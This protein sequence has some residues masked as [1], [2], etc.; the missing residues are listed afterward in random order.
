MKIPIHLGVLSAVIVGA[1]VRVDAQTTAPP[2]APPLPVVG[3]G[4][5][6]PEYQGL[7]CLIGAIIAAVG[8]YGYSDI[9]A[10]AA[11]GAVTNP[12]LLVPV[13]AT[14]FAVGCAVGSTA[15]PAFLPLIRAFRS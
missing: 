10:V 5:T 3:L 6:Q 11:T 12:V 13:M 7:G 8:T 15:S 1:S 2:T 9:V 4:L 14:G